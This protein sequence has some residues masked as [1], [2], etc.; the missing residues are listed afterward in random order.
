MVVAV[1]LLLFVAVLPAADAY[2]AAR[3]YQS[4]RT[5]CHTK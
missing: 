2:Y 4:E 3:Y 5:D 1:Q